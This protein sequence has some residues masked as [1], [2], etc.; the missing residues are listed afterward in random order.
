MSDFAKRQ[1]MR[2]AAGAALDQAA[3]LGFA[4]SARPWLAAFFGV[5]M[6]LLY[7]EAFRLTMW[8]RSLSW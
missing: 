7:R 8:V 1:I 2:P 4:D 6:I 3:P 5:L